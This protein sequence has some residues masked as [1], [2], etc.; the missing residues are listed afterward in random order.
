MDKKLR[1]TTNL[2]VKIQWWIQGRGP[3]GKILYNND[4]NLNLYNNDLEQI[5]YLPGPKLRR[6]TQIIDLRDTD[7]SRSFAISTKFNNFLIIRSPS[8]FL[9]EHLRKQWMRSDLSFSPKSVGKELKEKSV[10]RILFAV[11][12]Y[13]S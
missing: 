4:L 2:C 11:E 9:N 13:C 7:K 10:S 1:E 6:L 12:Y 5:S 8:L 3:R